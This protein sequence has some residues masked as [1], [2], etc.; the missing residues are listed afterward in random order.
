MRAANITDPSTEVVLSV[1]CINAGKISHCLVVCTKLNSLLAGC[2][3]TARVVQLLIDTSPPSMRAEHTG[4][5]LA[6]DMVAENGPSSA[7]LL[8]IFRSTK[9]AGDQLRNGMSD[10]LLCMED[11]VTI[12]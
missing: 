7:G 4:C 9:S 11:F 5:K 2:L 10:R 3:F 1:L 12:I 6:V 8:L